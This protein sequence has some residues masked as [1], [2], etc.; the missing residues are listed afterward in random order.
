MVKELQNHHRPFPLCYIVQWSKAQMRKEALY[1]FHIY[2]FA[3][4]L[5]GRDSTAGGM[6]AEPITAQ[7]LHTRWRKTNLE[8]PPALVSIGS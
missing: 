7:R 3:F 4:R 8:F 2:L 5:Q 6:G 1:V